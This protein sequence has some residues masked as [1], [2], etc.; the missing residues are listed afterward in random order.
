METFDPNGGASLDRRDL[1]SR[2]YG[3]NNSTFLHIKHI[4][5]GPLGFREEGFFSLLVYGNS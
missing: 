3:G 4:S 5:C 1:I 2:I